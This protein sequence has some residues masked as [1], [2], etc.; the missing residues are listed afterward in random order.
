MSSMACVITL[1][2]D[3]KSDLIN[4]MQQTASLF[5][6]KFFLREFTR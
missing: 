1:C 4:N 6:R 2:H 5:E 3:I